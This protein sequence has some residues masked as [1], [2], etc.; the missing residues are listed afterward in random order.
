LE[1]LAKL[2]A[3]IQSIIHRDNFIYTQDCE[4][5][6]DMILNL[7]RRFAPLDKAREQDVLTAWKKAIKKPIKG[8]EIEKWV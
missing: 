2:R 6:W 3:K 5:V 8:T 4:I 7:R 1:A